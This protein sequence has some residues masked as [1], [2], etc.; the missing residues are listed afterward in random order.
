MYC[1]NNVNEYKIYDKDHNFL[2]ELKYIRSEMIEYHNSSVDIT[3]TNA[4]MDDEYMKYTSN[5]GIYVSKISE[6]YYLDST[7]K[8]TVEDIYY[9]DHFDINMFYWCDDIPD[10]TFHFYDG[11]KI[12]KE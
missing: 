4:F 5:K 11:C 12:D 1:E 9:F 8:Q 7:E 6:H 10:Y 3:L 2:F